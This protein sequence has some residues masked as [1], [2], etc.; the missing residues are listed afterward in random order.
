M[1]N[2]VRRDTEVAEVVEEDA[3]AG[4]VVEED[5][6]TGRRG[7]GGRSGRTSRWRRMQ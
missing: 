4:L 6:M 2:L 5:A 1:R 3:V 7:G